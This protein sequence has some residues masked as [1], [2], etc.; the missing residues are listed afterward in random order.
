MKRQSKSAERITQKIYLNIL[1][2]VRER[3]IGS[4]SKPLIG[5]RISDKICRVDD[6]ADGVADGVYYPQDLQR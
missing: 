2:K 5:V 4:I 1:G 3:L 6:G